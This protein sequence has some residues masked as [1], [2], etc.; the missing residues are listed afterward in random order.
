MKKINTIEKGFHTVQLVKTRHRS[1][2]RRPAWL[3]DSLRQPKQYQR[4]TLKETKVLFTCQSQ[5]GDSTMSTMKLHVYPIIIIPSKSMKQTRNRLRLAQRLSM[6]RLEEVRNKA[7]KAKSQRKHSGA[8]KLKAR[9]K[10]LGLMVR[11]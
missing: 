11:E 2:V 5:A 6:K 8:T 7:E 4:E 10:N 3:K 9:N 1:G